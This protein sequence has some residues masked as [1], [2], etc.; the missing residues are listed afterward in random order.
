MEPFFFLYLGVY[1]LHILAYVRA[2]KPLSKPRS[3][4]RLSA[5]GL[6]CMGL[7]FMQKDVDGA[8]LDVAGRALAE[9]IPGFAFY[10]AIIGILKVY[11]TE[12]PIAVFG[13]LVVA[14]I[15][16]SLCMVTLVLG[17]LLQLLS[18]SRK[19]LPE[20][21][22]ASIRES[23]SFMLIISFIFSIVLIPLFFFCP[24]IV[25]PSGAFQTRVGIMFA[26][27]AFLYFIFYLAILTYY[28][29]CGDWKKS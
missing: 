27:M 11:A 9:K 25:S 1:L 29:F 14:L 5:L 15:L 13:S 28:L 24:E 12:I 17:F 23:F 18:N 20:M 16:Y 21:T 3:L 2:Q 7:G 26:N 10:D 22:W 8:N 19:P 4:I 6:L